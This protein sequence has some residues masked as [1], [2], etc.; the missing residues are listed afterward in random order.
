[1]CAPVRRQSPGPATLPIPHLAP[2]FGSAASGPHDLRTS[3]RC[4]RGAL[5]ILP[6]GPAR[7]ATNPRASTPD[8]RLHSDEDRAPQGV[9]H[10]LARALPAD[11]AEGIP[12]GAVPHT[13]ATDPPPR[14]TPPR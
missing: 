3:A 2:V 11:D 6:C 7:P 13:P 4:G 10:W 5:T 8:S 14:S 12:A 9:L 1:M